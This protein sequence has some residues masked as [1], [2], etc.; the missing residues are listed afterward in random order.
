MQRIV[1]NIVICLRMGKTYTAKILPGDFK[2]ITPEIP[3]LSQQ[4]VTSKG[5]LV[6]YTNLQLNPYPNTQL[7][8]FFSDNFPFQCTAPKYVINQLRGSQY[9]TS[10]TN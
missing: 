1:N 4:A 7:D 5:I 8:L 10:I 6:P 9:A 2:V 3:L